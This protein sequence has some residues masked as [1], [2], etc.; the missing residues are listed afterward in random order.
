MPNKNFIVKNGIEVDGNLIFADPDTNKVGI[1]TSTPTVELDVSGDI[2][3]NNLTVSDVLS[4]YGNIAINGELGEVGSF[5]SVTG[6]GVTW[7]PIPG[8]RTVASIVAAPGQTLINAVYN[9]STGVDVFVDGVRLTSTDYTANTGTEIV[10]AVS[11]FGGER[12]DII[13]YSVFG[14]DG[15]GITIENNSTQVG[16]SNVISTINFVGFSS[17][18]LSED[19]FGI[20][21]ENSPENYY[22]LGVKNE[23]RFYE[24]TLSCP[25]YISLKAPG[26]LTS[27]SSYQLPDNYPVGNEYYLSSSSVGIMTWKQKTDTTII[28]LTSETKILEVSTLT[29]IPYWPENTFLSSQPIWMVNTAATGSEIIFDIRI[30]NSSIFSVLPTIDQVENSSATAAIPSSFSTSFVNNNKMIS[31]G[32]TVTFH[33]VGIGS[34][35]AGSGAKVNIYSFS[36]Q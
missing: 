10:L 25:D 4:L 34:T 18:S 28:P 2:R 29:T 33:C 35:Y 8:L 5:L 3:S 26:I 1:K 21:L 6:S 22:N 15:P 7:S 14:T 12:V 11:L 32:S 9:P 27:T 13:A 19:G 16:L 30:N 24:N 36:S 23:I 31:I 20:T 17:I